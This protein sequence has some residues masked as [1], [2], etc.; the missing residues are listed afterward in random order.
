[1]SVPDFGVHKDVIVGF[2][3]EDATLAPPDATTS[4]PGEVEITEML[5]PEILAHIR[6]DGVSSEGGGSGLVL[7]R[8]DPDSRVRAGDR[9][10]LELSP[11]PLRVFDPASGEALVR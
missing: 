10:G 11:A 3:P 7:V 2:R 5:G 1:M 6:L 4:F 8:V 9:V